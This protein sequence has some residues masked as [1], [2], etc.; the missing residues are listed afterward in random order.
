MQITLPDGEWA[1]VREAEDLDDGT[2]KA[3]VRAVKVQYDRESKLPIYPASMED[4]VYDALLKEVLENWSYP[5]P[6]PKDDPASLN[7]LKIR[8]ARALRKA[9]QGH[10]DLING[11]DEDA[12][13]TPGS[14]N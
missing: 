14:E 8:H 11:K 5:F 10:M 13:P 6:L 1:T 2:R 7:K 3:V 4:D 9:L 12:D